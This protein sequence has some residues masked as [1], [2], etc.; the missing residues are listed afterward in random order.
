MLFSEGSSSVLI[1][2]P[3]S[4]CLV[5]QFADICLFST[6]QYKCTVAELESEWVPSYSYFF[7]LKPIFFP[8]LDWRNEFLFLRKSEPCLKCNLARRKWRWVLKADQTYYE[9]DNLMWCIP[10]CYCRESCPVGPGFTLSKIY[11]LTPLLA[12]NKDKRGLALD[13]QL[14]HE[15]TNLASSTML[16]LYSFFSRFLIIFPLFRNGLVRFSIIESLLLSSIDWLSLCKKK[17]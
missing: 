12:N 13:G 6:A 2:F 8:F 9:D 17:I 5:R 15:D 4:F 3:L 7:F 16:V 10:S 1:F 14:K 11:Y